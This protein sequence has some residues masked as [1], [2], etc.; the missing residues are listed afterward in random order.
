M[1]GVDP[2]VMC[3]KH[4]L[5]EH[6]EMHMMIGTLQKKRSIQGFIDNDLMEVHNVR[7]RHDELVKEMKRRGMN[8][9]SPLPEYKLFKAGKINIEQ[10]LKDLARRCKDC[11]KMQ[12]SAE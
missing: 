5:G 6:V 8:H 10:N 7:R 4:L 1:W 2:K 11:A 12:S 3:R 9:N